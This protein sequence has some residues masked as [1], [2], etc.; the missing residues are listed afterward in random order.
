MRALSSSQA[1][2]MNDAAVLIAGKAYWTSGVVWTAGVRTFP[3]LWNDVRGRTVGAG[4]GSD[5][6]RNGEPLKKGK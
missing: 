3:W 4:R 6:P 1:P 2:D 5:A